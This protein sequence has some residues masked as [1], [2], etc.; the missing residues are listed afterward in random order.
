M[1]PG[2][3]F[4][5]VVFLNVLWV[6]SLGLRPAL[7]YEEIDVTSGGILTGKVELKG[8]PPPARIFHLIFSPNIDLCGKISDGKGNRLLKDFKVAKDGSFQDVVVAV[9]GMKKGKKFD[10]APEIKI[11]NCR[12]SPFVTPVRNENPILI[13]N[14]DPITHDIQGYSLDD[15]YTFAMFNKPMIPKS[16][17][18]KSIHF[19]NGSY[20]FR[21]QCGVHDFMQSWGMAVGN[22][23]FAVT[24]ENGSF[25]ILDIPAGVYDVI[26]WHPHMKVLAQEVTIPENGQATLD[27]EFDAA[28]VNI[29]LHDLQ[30]ENR[31]ETALQ[32]HHLIPPTVELQTP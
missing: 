32:P 12:I 24:D 28:G 25:S 8:T 11:E 30:T 26:A 16:E 4:N 15:H 18:S 2:V 19:R 23:Y 20:I 5:R 10:Y 27:F 7:G 29:P 22:P 14:R 21:T 17:A 1:N 9:V 6:L 13:S 3:L 31:I